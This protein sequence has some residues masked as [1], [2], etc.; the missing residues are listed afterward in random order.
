[1]EAENITLPMF[2]YW[3]NSAIMRCNFF[4]SRFRQ[5]FLELKFQFIEETP[6][7]NNICFFS[8]HCCVI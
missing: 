2:Q 6:A 7:I 8:G 3:V 1:M 5:C 4:L